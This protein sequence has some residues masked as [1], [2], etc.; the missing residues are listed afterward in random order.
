ML[1]GLD[2]CL[3]NE[4]MNTMADWINEEWKDRGMAGGDWVDECPGRA[5]ARRAWLEEA[6]FL[7]SKGSAA[8]SPETLRGGARTHC[9]KM[10]LGCMESTVILYS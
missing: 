8:L 10:Q 7:V 4:S 1:K 5:E 2:K 3:M 6:G 9:E